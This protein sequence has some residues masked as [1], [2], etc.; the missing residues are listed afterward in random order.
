MLG[1]VLCLN[2]ECPVLYVRE[3]AAR[4]EAGAAHRLA[5][6]DAAAAEGCASFAW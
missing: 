4:A 1:P 2:A 6:L 5:R 3:G